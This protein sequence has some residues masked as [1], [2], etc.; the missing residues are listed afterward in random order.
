VTEQFD[1]Y[2]APALSATQVADLV[3]RALAIEFRLHNSDY[4]GGDYFRWQGDH[5]AEVEVVV[6]SP[7]DE[8]YLLESEVPGMQVLVFAS[9]LDDAANETLRGLDGIELVRSDLV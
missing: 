3:A 7:D 4:L 6:N 8:G 9:C 1:L 2:V 5:Y